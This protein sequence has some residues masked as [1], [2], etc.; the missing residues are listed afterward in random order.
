MGLGR[1]PA[2]GLA[3]ARKRAT[4]ALRLASDGTDPRHQ[5][6]EATRKRDVLMSDAIADYLAW[7][8]VNNGAGTARDKASLFNNHVLRKLGAKPIV[9]VSRKDI[10]TILD[11]LGDRPARRRTAYAY[12]R[13]FFQWAAER[14]LVDQNPCLV[15]RTPKAVPSRER[16]LTDEEIRMLWTGESVLAVMAKLQLMTAQRTGSIARMRWDDLDLANKTWNIPAGDMKS[17]RQHSVPLSNQAIRLLE[18]WPRLSG[19]F[20]FGTG[21]N[22]EKPFNGRS[23]GMKRLRDNGVAA[24]WRL[25]DLRRTAVTLAQRGGASVDEIRALTQHKVPGVIGV[26]ARHKYDHEKETV[27]ARIDSEL[28]ALIHN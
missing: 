8:E 19:P 21:S 16:V 5:R 22:G 27:I 18:T 24:D 7:S 14:E 26:Y 28:F 9:S 13:H 20:V 23:K 2:V 12:I 6:E 1:Y 25:H 15:V 17:G 3:E 11:K 4:D 10:S